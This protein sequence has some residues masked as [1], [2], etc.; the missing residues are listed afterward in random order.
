MRWLLSSPFFLFAGS[1]ISRPSVSS[2]QSGSDLKPNQ[3]NQG[4]IKD[5]WVKGSLI[6]QRGTPWAAL[7]RTETRST[8]GGL[9]QAAPAI[10]LGELAE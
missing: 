5:H 6:P 1:V 4:K 9:S 2:G 3:I 7:W 8:V 10:Y